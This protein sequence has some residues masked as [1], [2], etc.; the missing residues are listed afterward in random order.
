MAEPSRDSDAVPAAELYPLSAAD[1]PRAA[2]IANHWISTSTA[3]FHEGPRTVDQFVEEVARHADPRHGCFGIRVGGELAGY[4][5]VSA[6]KGRCAYRDTA[7][8]SVY[9]APEMTGRGV[10]AQAIRYAVEH[11][12]QHRLHA[13]LAVICTENIASLRAFERAG[14]VEVGRLREVGR[15]FGR[16]LDV[17]YL[18]LLL[19]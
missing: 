6:F 10:G 17:A 15:K 8:V 1:H 7:E 14:F 4:L 2:E 16:L 5:V 3:T 9:L 13:L 18:E 19:G 12:R 11:A